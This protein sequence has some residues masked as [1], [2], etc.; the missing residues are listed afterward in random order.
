MPS[1]LSQSRPLATFLQVK[2]GQKSGK[3][4]Q[5]QS[6]EQICIIGLQCLGCGLFLRLK[7]KDRQAGQKTFASRAFL[8]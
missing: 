1:P 3:M 7:L 6:S 4:A 8:R 2:I 5:N